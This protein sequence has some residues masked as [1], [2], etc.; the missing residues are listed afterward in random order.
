MDRDLRY[1]WAYNQKT[2]PQD[3]I[4]GRTDADI[5]TPGEAAHLT[6]IKRRVLE[7]DV[8]VREQMWLDWPGGPIY[9]D[10]YFEPFHD[11]TGSVTGV[12]IATV[13][14]TRRR[15][16][17]ERA[18]RLVEQHRLALDA[19][20]M[21]WWHYDPVTRI[22][23]YDDRYREIF[24]VTGESRPNDEILKRLHPDDR[25]ASGSGWRP[26]WTRSIRNRY[27]AEYRIV[28]P[29]GAVKWIEAHGLATFEGTGG[30]RRATSLVGTVAEIT[31]RKRTEDALRESEARF[32]SLTETSPIALSV[33][34][35]DGRILYVNTAHEA[36]FGY[37]WGR[38]G[39]GACRR[40]LLRSG[41]P[42]DDARHSPGAG[43]CQGSRGQVT[44][45]GR[46]ALLGQ[47]LLL[48]DRIRRP[49]GHPGPH[50]RYHR[51]ERGR[52]RVPD[53]RREPAAVERGPGA[54]RVRLEPRPAGAAA[55][56]RQF[57][58]TPRTAVQGQLGEDADEYID[59]IVEGGIR[60]QTLIQDLLAY[61]RV[62]TTKQDLRPTDGGR[63]GRGGAEPRPPAPRGRGRAHARPAADGA[64]RPAPARAGLREPGL[65]RDQVP[66]RRTCRCG[67]TSAHG[68]W[69]ASGSSRSRDNGIGIEPE[70][71]D[72]IFVIFQRLHTKD[73]YP[74]TGIGLA[75]VKRIV[76]RHGGTIRV[77]STPG[78]G[79]TFYFTLP[80]KL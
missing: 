74:G 60:M 18:A 35:A 54:V 21:G 8:E 55:V 20:R 9:L 47:P 66:P 36:L 68:G 52:G 56:D 50:H 17:E 51:T 70:Y 4:V 64:G 22:A 1:V 73:A 67:S 62:N 43:K 10:V 58:S 6:E 69:T 27:S 57:S 75:I 33:T 2:A 80:D 3:G 45:E 71:F 61:S 31:D 42:R 30:N 72:R 37:T 5:F 34:T 46:H 39:E 49:A 63:A 12:G 25:P 13:D 32:R 26:P 7:E 48:P 19:A 44:A 53:K 41:R 15:L 29:G 24:E 77:E 40:F 78:E 79:T 76:D 38:S 23:W 65:E 11:E 14:L 28:M 59:F 16:A